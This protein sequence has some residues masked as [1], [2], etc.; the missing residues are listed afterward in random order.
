MIIPFTVQVS[1]QSFQDVTGLEGLFEL[2]EEYERDIK[3]AGKTAL[4]WLSFMEMMDV[5]FGRI[6]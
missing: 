3:Q 4:Y 2:M 1:F 6:C 5:L